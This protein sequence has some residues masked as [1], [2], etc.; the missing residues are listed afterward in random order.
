VDG[1]RRRRAKS[2]DGEARHF[3]FVFV[4]PSLGKMTYGRTHRQKGDVRRSRLR[5]L[6][7]SSRSRFYV[8]VG[9]YLVLSITYAPT[10]LDVGTYL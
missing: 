3:V 5:K 9:T 10:R 2:D 4:V 1:G 6:D 8:Y 7:V